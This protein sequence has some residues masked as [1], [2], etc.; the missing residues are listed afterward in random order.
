MLAVVA[1]SLGIESSLQVPFLDLTSTFRK[2]DLSRLDL[3]SEGA[4]CFFGNLYHLLVRHMLLVL[5]PP[6][7][8]K[9]GGDRPAYRLLTE[10]PPGSESP[11]PRPSNAYLL[12]S[13][14]FHGSFDVGC[15]Q[16]ADAPATGNILVE[17]IFI[18]GRA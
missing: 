3:D 12:P 7:S 16:Y 8:A 13:S 2:V 1:L 9:V 4:V 15:Q 11:C 14:T 18:V 6:S 5:G 17:C 10:K